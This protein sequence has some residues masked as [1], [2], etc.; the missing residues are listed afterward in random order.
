[1]AQDLDFLERHPMIEVLEPKDLHQSFHCNDTSLPN[2]KALSI[3]QSIV[4]DHST[5]LSC[6]RLL[7]GP[8]SSFV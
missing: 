3:D 4:F 6:S 2:L 1:M 8:S 7:V 5:L